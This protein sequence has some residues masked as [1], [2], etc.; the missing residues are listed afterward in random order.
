MPISRI[1]NAELVFV[2]E[3]FCIVKLLIFEAPCTTSITE[4][5]HF[6]HRKA[7]RCTIG[8]VKYRLM[9]RRQ[10]INRANIWMTVKTKEG[11]M[12]IKEGSKRMSIL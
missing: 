4:Y 8:R 11:T 6:A 5:A 12:I 2:T 10:R 7:K 3:Y 9:N 1:L